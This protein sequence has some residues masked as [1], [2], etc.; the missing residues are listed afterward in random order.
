V[1]VECPSYSHTGAH[2]SDHVRCHMIGE[3]EKAHMVDEP[4]VRSLDPDLDYRRRT[5]YVGVTIFMMSLIQYM[6]ILPV[7]GT[8]LLDYLGINLTQFGVLMSMRDIGGIVP[9]LFVGWIIDR[10]GARRAL[11]VGLVGSGVSLLI[12]A[13]CGPR[14]RLMGAGI[15]ISIVFL[16]T[17]EMSGSVFAVQLFSE[18]RRRILSL[19]SVVRDIVN[20]L[21]SALGEGGLSLVQAVPAI[22]FAAVL[23]VPFA[24]LA[25]VFLASSTLFRQK[26]QRKTDKP[27]QWRDLLISP[28]SVPLIVLMSI[29]GAADATTCTWM[30]IFLK[31]KSFQNIF[32]RPGFVISAFSA[33]YVI[34]RFALALFPERFGRR[35]FLVLPGVLGG[36]VFIA[37]LLSRS[38]ILTPCSYVLG[39]FLWSVEYPA[40]LARLA[41]E[42]KHRFGA[43]IAVLTLGIYGTCAATKWLMGFFTDSL[44]EERMWIAMIVAASGFVCV[45]IGCTLWLLFIGKDEEQN[46]PHTAQTKSA[47]RQ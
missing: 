17:L 29:H 13:L 40:L 12:I 6:G 32:I 34:S 20:T 16:V 27:W 24:I 42:E 7:F 9:A 26:T 31:S 43:A 46:V 18:Q 5:M 11:R 1:R 25:V 23:H 21:V 45:S 30:P 38:P 14:W 3:I 44:G 10:W 15:G 8:D 33:A 41:E 39:A 35:A 28:S 37:G 22:S 19:T 36:S 2:T 47:D 4:A